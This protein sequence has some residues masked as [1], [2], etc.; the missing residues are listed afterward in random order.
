MS[1]KK[2]FSEAVDDV[3]KASSGLFEVII[4]ELKMIQAVEWLD[5]QLKRIIK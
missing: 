5:M 1:E 3:R 4:K 2:T